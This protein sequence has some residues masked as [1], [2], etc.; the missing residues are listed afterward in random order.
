MPPHVHLY[1]LSRQ[2]KCLPILYHTNSFFFFNFIVLVFYVGYILNDK[3]TLCNGCYSNR[4]ISLIHNL[5]VLSTVFISSHV[6]CHKFLEDVHEDS[7]QISSQLDGSYA[8]IRTNLWRHPDAPQC[9]EVSALKTSGRQGNTIQTQ[10]Q[11]F[12]ISTW[13]WISVDTY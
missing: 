13:S 7:M 3:N 10:G 9:L 11:A 12:L 6:P 8:T 1:L 4:I 5:Q 2:N